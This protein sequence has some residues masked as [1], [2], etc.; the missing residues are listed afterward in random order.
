MSLVRLIFGDLSSRLVQDVYKRWFAY[1]LRVA[2]ALIIVSFVSFIVGSVVLFY[3]YGILHGDL[4]LGGLI[5][6]Y[7][8]IMFSQ[9][10]GFTRVMPSP[11]ASLVLGVFTFLWF[12]P[13]FLVFGLVGFS[14]LSSFYSTYCS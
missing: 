10:T 1:Q 9:H 14:V 12:W 8:G 3:R 13:M 5:L 2:Q 7:M 11:L 4:M 6:F